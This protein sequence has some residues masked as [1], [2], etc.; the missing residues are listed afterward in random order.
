MLKE[1]CCLSFSP[2][3]MEKKSDGGFVFRCSRAEEKEAR[4]HDNNTH[5][6]M[7]IVF[8]KIQ[9][10]FEKE[11]NGMALLLSVLK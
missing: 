3:W 4:R 11:E 2:Q 10:Q 8:A 7:E 5:K 6:A 1:R 9:A